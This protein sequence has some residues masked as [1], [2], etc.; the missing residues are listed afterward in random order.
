MSL[1]FQ[2]PAAKQ[3]LLVP[4]LVLTAGTFA[5][6]VTAAQ[7]PDIQRQFLAGIALII[8]AWISAFDLRTLRAPNVVVYPASLFVVLAAFSLGMT[9]G[10]AALGGG[11]LTLLILVV[12]VL[13]GRGAMGFGD[14]K[15]GFICGAIVGIHGM[16]PMLLGTFA[17]G[18]CFA[19]VVLGLRLRT[20]ADVVAFT[21]FLYA[22]VLVSLWL[23]N[24]T[25]FMNIG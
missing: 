13:I 21:P 14:A 3:Q 23:T 8:L 7:A 18:G 2:K 16:L 15:V 9:N 6:I 20:R 25:V 10:L 12:A 19:A 22:G 17:I 24:D 5:A 11:V 4:R 1:V